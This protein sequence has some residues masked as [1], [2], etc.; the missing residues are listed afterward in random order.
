MRGLI[1]PTIVVMFAM[2]EGVSAA[3][4]PDRISADEIRS[5]KLI[6]GKARGMLF[7]NVKGLSSIE[8]THGSG[9]SR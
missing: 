8:R 6:P 7:S 5:V 4:S 3:P 1:L 9:S 2:V